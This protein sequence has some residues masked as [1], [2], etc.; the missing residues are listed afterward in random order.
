VL[1][2]APVGKTR[3]GLIFDDGF[4]PSTLAT[5]KL[6]EE[7][8]LPAFFAV[9]AEPG[10]W[11]PQFPKGDFAL[12]NELQARGHIIQPHGLTH[13]KLSELPHERAVGEIERCMATFAERLDHFD[14]A[15]SVYCYAYNSATRRLNEWLMCRV[16]AVRQQ[17]S[18][19]LSGEDLLRGFWHSDAIG[20]HD[21]GD[22]LFALLDRA[23]AERPPAFLFTL[24]GL[25]GE[26]WG[27]ITTA[28]L[29]RVLEII[30]S[31]DAFEYWPVGR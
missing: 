17:G 27:A 5:A 13:A 23:R 7:F 4:V 30:T 19:F 26:A 20:P 6:F 22:E 25:D 14:P 16:R 9:I 31:D 1:T 29:R 3:V 24:H 28:K 2:P 11:A 8:S 21:P 15:R 18:G 10:D 12:W